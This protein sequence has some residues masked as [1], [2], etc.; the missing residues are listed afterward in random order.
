MRPHVPKQYWRIVI[1]QKLIHF[2]VGASPDRI[3]NALVQH[4]PTTSAI[5]PNPGSRPVS[6]ADA[7]AA[8]MPLDV[9]CCYTVKGKFPVPAAIAK[10][11]PWE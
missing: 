8:T 2:R 3:K 4:L 11:G 7:P 1:D 9:S 10:T 6:G 5:R